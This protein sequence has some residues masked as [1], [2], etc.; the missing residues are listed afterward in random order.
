MFQLRDEHIRAFQSVAVDNFEERA[1]RHLRKHLPDRTSQL[2]DDDLR[3]RVHR[4]MDRA[5][6]YG[7]ATEREIMCFVDTSFL[8]G[9]YFDTET[10][11]TWKILGDA[12]SSP[13]ERAHRLLGKAEKIATRS[14]ND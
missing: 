10:S 12:S 5:K 4:G 13:D 7:F 11:W 8:L 3:R 1:V 14:V 2:T 6:T 9:E